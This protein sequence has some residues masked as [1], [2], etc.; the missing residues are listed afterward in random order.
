MAAY[1]IIYPSHFEIIGEYNKLSPSID[2]KSTQ[3]LSSSKY[4]LGREDL[5]PTDR[6]PEKR[7]LSTETD[8]IIT[9]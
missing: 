6:R 4:V 9:E 1:T 2:I 3:K 7:E 8:E 5:F